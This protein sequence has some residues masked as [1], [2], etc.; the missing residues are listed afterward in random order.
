[1][2]QIATRPTDAQPAPRAVG[3]LLAHQRWVRWGCA[4]VLL[5]CLVLLVRRLPLEGLVR[6]SKGWFASLGAWGPPAFGGL[7]VVGS[8]V[9]V[10][11]APM[12]M[13][14]GFL[15]RHFWVAFLTVNLGAVATGAVA[16]LAA[17]HLA[18]HRVQDYVNRHRKFAALDAALEQGGWKILLL[19]RL[20]PAVPFTPVN[21]ALGL[22]R[23]RLGPYLLATWLG[24]MP[25]TLLYVY[26]GETGAALAGGG[27]IRAGQWVYLGVGL[28]ATVAATVYLARLS[29]EKLKEQ[30]EMQNQ[31]DPSDKPD[32]PAAWKPTTFLLL[33]LALA[34]AGGTAWTFLHP[35]RAAA[36]D[37]PAFA[38]D[39]SAFDALL[40]AHVNGRG[41][42]DYQGMKADRDQL[43]TYLAA[44]AAADVQ[45]M[46][47]DEHLALLLNAY[48][49]CTLEL[50]LDHGIPASI[51][52][53]PEAER[54]KAKRWGI[55][56]KT[57]SLDE[58]ENQQIRPTFNEPRVHFALVCAAESCPPLRRE[59]YTGAAVASQLEDQA[60]YCMTH[61]RWLQYDGGGAIRLTSIM[62]WY[63]G[64]FKAAG[65]VLGFVAKYVP[66]LKKQLDD[67]AKPAV[68]FLAYSWK[69]NSQ[70]NV[71]AE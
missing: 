60:K 63:G 36:A 38:F 1:M 62:D 2:S 67:G 45:G 71:P 68:K 31:P 22:T 23:A 59:A 6:G 64:D 48:N 25:G 11:G 37:A 21:Y 69:L 27:K 55:G 46:G 70:A 30:P 53:I 9:M 20:S 3:G 26:L 24:T 4:I 40:K 32:R 57:Y 65:G 29:R 14:A 56:G 51:Q 43:K 61:P 52:D 10:P 8:L 39:H 42:V 41:G 19:L 18:R 50:I 47:R 5:V 17:R 34:A 28:A 35:P 54:W 16:F 49:A 58:I 7:Y 13:A 44:L 66:A 12:T 33:A 15:F